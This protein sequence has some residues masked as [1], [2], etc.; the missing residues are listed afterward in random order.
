M[1]VSELMGNP[2]KGGGGGGGVVR[3][4]MECVNSG[5]EHQAPVANEAVGD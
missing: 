2:R 3:L 4:L 1:K 5:E